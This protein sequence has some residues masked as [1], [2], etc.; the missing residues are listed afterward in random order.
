[1]LES[2]MRQTYDPRTRQWSDF[3]MEHGDGFTWDW[4]PAQRRYVM[5]WRWDLD[6]RPYSTVTADTLTVSSEGTS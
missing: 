2:G 5:R 6:L 1:M 4:S 3:T